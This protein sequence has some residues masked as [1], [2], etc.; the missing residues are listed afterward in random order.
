MKQ[1]TQ[2]HPFTLL[3][4]PEDF[5][6]LISPTVEFPRP[7]SLLFVLWN[8]S[9]LNDPGNTMNVLKPPDETSPAPP[10]TSRSTLLE[11]L[12]DRLSLKTKAAG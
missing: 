2:F 7:P 5:N 9:I 3:L 1:K 12:M 11:D 10:W 4:L 8:L 6:P